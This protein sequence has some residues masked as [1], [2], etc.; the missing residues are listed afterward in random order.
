MPRCPNCKKEIDTLNEIVYRYCQNKVWLRICATVAELASR[1]VKI[2]E[3]E[4]VHYECPEC[5]SAVSFS[6]GNALSFLMEE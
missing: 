5:N 4:T 1:E 3:E 6:Y 2:L